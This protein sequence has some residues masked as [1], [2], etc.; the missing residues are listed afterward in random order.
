MHEESAKTWLPF[1]GVTLLL[2][3]TLPT[4][5]LSRRGLSLLQH[6]PRSS[7]YDTG[8]GSRASYK[9][10]Q[11]RRGQTAAHGTRDCPAVT[12]TPPLSPRPVGERAG[13][14]AGGVQPHPGGR[15]LS[16]STHPAWRPRPTRH[17]TGAP[18]TTCEKLHRHSRQ[19][20]AFSTV[21]PV[22]RLEATLRMTRQCQPSTSVTGRSAA[23]EGAT[24]NTARN[25]PAVMAVAGRRK[26]Q[27]SRQQ[28]HVPSWD[29]E[30]TVS[31]G[32]RRHVRVPFLE[33][34]AHAQRPS[35]EPLV[36]SH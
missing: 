1:E 2:K 13:R 21:E 16:T 34:L 29:S 22:P 28:A 23:G 15:T 9:L 11:G 27:S 24:V 20:R 31:H 8:A 33:R 30:K 5:V 25:G 10:A 14:H 35:H 3:A 26:R 32:G 7:H 12:S 36:P 6:A 4:C 19:Y 18:V 17:V